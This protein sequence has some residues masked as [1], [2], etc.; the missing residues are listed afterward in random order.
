MPLYLHNLNKNQQG[1]Q[2]QEGTDDERSIAGGSQTSTMSQATTNT[3]K[4]RNSMHPSTSSSSSSVTAAM[5]RASL[6]N[7]SRSIS[8]LTSK[9]S[10]VS[11]QGESQKPFRFGQHNT[12]QQNLDTYITSTRRGMSSSRYFQN[13]TR[14]EETT[15]ARQPIRSESISDARSEQNL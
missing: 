4:S 6:H 14:N 2:R 5:K 11:N 10:I 8:S 12:A 9:G 7:R 13:S 15:R 3:Q 1:S